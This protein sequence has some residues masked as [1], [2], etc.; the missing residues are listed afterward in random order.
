MELSLLLSFALAATLT[1][2]GAAIAF[3]TRKRPPPLQALTTAL[4]R[5]G[6]MRFP[7]T[8]SFAARDGSA[9]SYREY[10]VAGARQVAVLLHGSIHDSR[11]MHSIG[12]LLSMQGVAVYALD[13][14]GHGG[15]GR[16]GDIDYIGQLEDDL[17]DLVG[18]IRSQHA[19][20]RLALVG[21]S[22]GGG[23][24][25]RFAGGPD[26]ALFDRYVAVAPFLH[27]AGRMVREEAVEWAVAAVPR[28]T[29]LHYLHAARL[30]WF[31]RLPVLLCAVPPGSDCTAD[32]SFR[33]ALNFRPHLDW[34]NDIRNIRS[35]TSILIGEADELFNAE[36]YAG[37][38]QGLNER[39]GVQVLKAVDHTTVCIKASA[40]M[41]IRKALV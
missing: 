4:E 21:H 40:V 38:L 6:S 34:Q 17:V 19:E 24:A 30:P 8:K 16:R 14:R 31:Q 26:G 28:F 7:A 39:V 41:A 2:F 37:L 36:A 20:A 9:L 11:T 32:Y 23:F 3:G 25:L 1:L 5:L 33:L 27:H 35:K 13:V 12:V 29:A 10:P 22:A 15:S 18:L